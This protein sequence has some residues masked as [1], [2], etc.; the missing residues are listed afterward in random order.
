M[1]RQIFSPSS[2]ALEDKAVS[3][4]SRENEIGGFH[5]HFAPITVT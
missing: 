3:Y 4:R 5:F 2:S 1:M